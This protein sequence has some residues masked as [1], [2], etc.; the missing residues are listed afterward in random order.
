M[1][2]W[3]EGYVSDIGYTHGYYLE[4][5]PHLIRLNS[6]DKFIELPDNQTACE[7]GFGQGLSVNIHAAASTTQWYGTD[8][9]PSQASY[10]Q[11]LAEASQSGAK[12]YDN[13]FEEFAHRTDLPDFDFIALHGIWSW[14]NDENRSIIVDFIRRKLKVGG[15]L[16]VSYNTMPAWS[17]FAPIRD[18]MTQHADVIGSQGS[19]IIN[20]IDGA[21]VFASNLIATNPAYA[22]ANPQIAERIEKL[23]GQNRN[24]LAHEY[25]N[26]DWHPMLFSQMAQWLEPAKV[27]FGCSA[28]LLDHVDQINLTPEQQ[29]FL[30]ELPD[31]MFRESV[32]DFMVNQQ[33]RK[34]Y[35]VKGVRKLTPLK[36]LELLRD[37]RF[38]LLK[39]ASEVALKMTTIMGE[40]TLNET[41]Y[42][43]FLSAL[44][45][46][47]IKSIGQ[48]EKELKGKGVELPSILQAVIILQGKG[49][50]IGVQDEDVTSKA[51]KSA[52]RLNTHL[53]EQA[54]D[55]ADVTY[56]ASPVTGGG[57]PINRFQQL[58]IAAHKLGRKQ[59]RELADHVW[60]L[61]SIQGQ[62]LLKEGKTIEDAEENI[63]ELTA[64]AQA[65]VD[66]QIP[67]LKAM[68]II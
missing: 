44:D 3:S 42:N 19:G 50:L 41:I 9:N 20:R 47:K 46:Y 14:I 54:R 64:Q 63:T 36:R 12:L 51:R 65:F 37:Q 49:D 10:A 33:F 24:Y 11:E 45:G 48:L 43:A 21:I 58:F 66:K 31:M 32:R 60:S 28:N 26:R 13:S 62:R 68:Q 30:A 8:F 6:L 38:I 57:I 61:L 16:Y 2:Y 18:L 27:Q 29:T 17:A 67:I 22:R 53:I 40:I 35:W 23:K 55:S 7:L 4:L 59:P 15:V 34:D 56:L 52:E 25:F 39:P 1:H 5:N